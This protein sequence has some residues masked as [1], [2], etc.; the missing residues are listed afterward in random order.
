MAWRSVGTNNTDLIRQ[1]KEYRVIAS[2]A[3]AEAM[4]ATDRK[5]Y[6]PRNPYMD[7]PQSIGHGVTISAPHMHAF[8]LE[9]LRDHMKP[10]AHVLDVGSGSGYLTACFY[11]YLQAQ[12]DNSNT[13]IVGIEHQP[14]LVCL[15]KENLNNDD[16]QMLQ[17][18]KLI[19]VEGDGRK[20]L[21]EH[22]P[23]NAI[24]VGAAAPETP[25]ALIEQ[26]AKGGRLIV[27]VGPEGG[28]QYMMQYD[29]DEDGN[30]KNTR[31]MGVMYVPLTDLRRS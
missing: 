24:H 30:V 15:S 28:E 27:P 18:G 11:R 5:F 21:P 20:G 31:L 23:Y 10:G 19:I 25:T 9:Y 22:A 1:L 12:G 8:A 17:S 16:P 29:K 13:R 7:A 6:S 26:L 3:V 4:I 2:D 14:E